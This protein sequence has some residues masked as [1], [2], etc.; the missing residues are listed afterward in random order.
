[1]NRIWI[2]WTHSTGKTTLLNNLNYKNT[3]QEIAREVIQ[4]LWVPQDMN[5]KERELFQRLIFTKQVSKE[6]ELEDFITDRTLFDVLAYSM[7]LP[8]YKQLLLQA[9][10]HLKTRPYTHVFYIPI[11]FTLESDWVRHT[12]EKY[13]SLIDK[14]ILKLLNELSIP[15]YTITWSVDER[16]EKIKAL[17]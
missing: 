17:I 7:D 10:K 13:R 11:E 3:I 12:C 4:I 15:Y 16:I 6:I 8:C 2:C 5:K 14:R 1:M 9:I